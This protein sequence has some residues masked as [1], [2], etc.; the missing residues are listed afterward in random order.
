M[1]RIDIEQHGDDFLVVLHGS[2]A[3]EWV[4]LLERYWRSITEKVPSASVTTSLS[5]VAYIDAAGLTLFDQMAR[6]GVKFQATGCMNKHLVDLV[7]G[8]SAASHERRPR[9]H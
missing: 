8:R 6:Q 1:L 5:D 3:G 7:Q 9:E 2:V 4:A